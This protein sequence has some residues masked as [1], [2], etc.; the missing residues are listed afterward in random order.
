MNNTNDQKR[1]VVRRKCQLK[2]LLFGFA[3]ISSLL[4]RLFVVA[5]LVA[6]GALNDTCNAT[7]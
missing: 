4:L 2:F 1:L 6:V 5:P 7:I 3:L